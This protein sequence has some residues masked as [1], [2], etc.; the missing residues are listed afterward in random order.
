M[1]ETKATRFWFMHK[2]SLL[3]YLN[4]EDFCDQFLMSMV[5]KDILTLEDLQTLNQPIIDTT[6]YFDDFYQCYCKHA[7][8]MAQTILHQC[9]DIISD[10]RIKD[11]INSLPNGYLKQD[12]NE[13]WQEYRT[14]V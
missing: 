14:S 13:Y 4:H 9:P 5:Q 8:V 7:I 12:M 2:D 10:D 3:L 1:N 6:Q 11:I